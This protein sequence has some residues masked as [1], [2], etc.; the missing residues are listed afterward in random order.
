MNESGIESW[1]LRRLPA[2][3]RLAV[4][5]LALV[6]LGGFAASAAHL[7]WHYENRDELPGLSRDDLEGAYHGVERI[8]PML[9]A[10][11]RGHPPEL[12]QDERD[13]LLK[14]LRGGKISED[15]D[16]LDLG[17]SAPVEII[18]RRC[19]MCHAA[20]PAEVGAGGVEP[21]FPLETWDD[22]K[23]VSFSRKIEPTPV[24]VLAMSTHAHALSLAVVT[25]M[26]CG[27]ALLTSWPGRLTRW[28]TALA[29]VALFAD[30]AAWWIA[31]EAAGA[32][33]LIIAAG[34]VYNGL[35]VV[36]LLAVVGDVMRPGKLK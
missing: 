23:K 28:A 32:V 31:R 22:V 35:M 25:A 27:L 11:E 19:T 12:P 4:A 2:S 7:Y 24:K 18:A 10:M 13:V 15:Y 9:T 21:S 1:R 6:L 3:L 16:N 36:M 34:G 30:F 14:W 8:A 17:D 5:A 33:W 29:C 26:V 20:R